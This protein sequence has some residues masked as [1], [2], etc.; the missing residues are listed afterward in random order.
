MCLL[1]QCLAAAFADTLLLRLFQPDVVPAAIGF[2][3]K[4]TGEYVACGHEAPVFP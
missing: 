2:Y 3:A 1:D 4:T